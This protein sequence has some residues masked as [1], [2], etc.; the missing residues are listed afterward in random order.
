MPVYFNEPLSM[1]QKITETCEYNDLLEAAASEENQYLRL[2]YVATYTI[3]RFAALNDRNTKPFNPLLGETYE[4]VTENFKILT[5]QVSH[6]PPVTAFH[7][8]GPTYKMV[9]STCTTMKFNGRYIQF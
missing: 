9:S 3:S 6:H 8:E 5:E 2:A 7:C 4:L 1:C